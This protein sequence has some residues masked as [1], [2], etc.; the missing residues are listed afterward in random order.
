MNWSCGPPAGRFRVR[1]LQTHHDER[2]TAAG[3]R[4][5]AINLAG[6]P[7]DAVGR[8]CTLATPGYLQPARYLD[9]WLA[10]LRMPGKV[11]RKTLR[12]RLHIA[13]NEVLTELRLIEKPEENT[14]AAQFAQLKTAEPIVAT[15]G[16]RFILRDESGK[17]TLGGGRVLRPAA[18]L[19]TAKRPAHQEGLQTLRD[20][21]PPA[22]LEEV[23]RAAEWQAL[24]MKQL[25]LRA[26]L[27]DENE[28]DNLAQRLMGAG[29]IRRLETT[30]TRQY[31]HNARLQALGDDLVRRLKQFVQDNPRLPGLPAFAVAELD[32]Q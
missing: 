32:A 28:A 9:V 22:R 8:G 14:V 4:R 5:L 29:K 20:G 18:R 17:R 16:Q 2:D 1:D 21:S 19:W 24:S 31:I 25:A 12:L 23:I 13:T 7:R 10:T 6:V 11:R 15:K 30:S 27:A 26:G 3:R